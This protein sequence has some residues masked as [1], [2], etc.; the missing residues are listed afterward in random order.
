MQSQQ[1]DSL[2][3]EA[4]YP[5]TV[6]HSHPHMSGQGFNS[7]KIQMLNWMEI[8]TAIKKPAP[9]TF[10]YLLLLVGF[11]CYIN[12]FI[13]YNPTNNNELLLFVSQWIYG[14]IIVVIVCMQTNNTSSGSCII[15]EPGLC[16]GQNDSHLYNMGVFFK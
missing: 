7:E 12:H 3:P 1:E 16:Y 6:L 5:P 14:F 8:V 9:E 2:T 15:A 13:S 4:A 11:W 10:S